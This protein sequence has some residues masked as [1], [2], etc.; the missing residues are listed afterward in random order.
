MNSA[1]DVSSVGRPTKRLDDR[2]LALVHDE[3][4]HQVD[5][6]EERV[7]QVRAVE[8]RVVL[9]PDAAAG[10]EERLEVLVVVVQVVLA[11]EQHLDELGVAACLSRCFHR[12]DVVEAA[13]AARDVAR[14]QRLAF[15][16]GDDAD[17]VLR[18]DAAR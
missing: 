15:E 9:Q 2:D 3:H 4:R 11:A 18:A 16:R 6:D 10:V 7:Q 5:A 13:E 12:G 14:R 8:Q 1:P 17:D